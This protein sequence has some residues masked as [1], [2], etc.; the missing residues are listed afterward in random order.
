MKKIIL[1]SLILVFLGSF[2]L[3][4]EDNS[5]F[6]QSWNQ[7]NTFMRPYGQDA[8]GPGIHSD[9]T[10]RPFIWQTNDGQT[11]PQAFGLSQMGMAS[12]LVKTSLAGL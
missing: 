2:Q 1:I 9:V 6:D 10:G 12:A 7:R 3:M 4:A 11:Y 8:Y 5:G